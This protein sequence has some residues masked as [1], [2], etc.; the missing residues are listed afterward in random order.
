MI[1]IQTFTFQINNRLK[2]LKKML[3]KLTELKNRIKLIAKI[4]QYHMVKL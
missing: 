4:L 2:R 3:L 1:Q